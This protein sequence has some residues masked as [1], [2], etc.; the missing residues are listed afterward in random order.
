MFATVMIIV[1]LFHLPKRGANVRNSTLLL[2]WFLQ[3]LSN[4]LVQREDLNKAQ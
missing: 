3:A 2:K 4:R 1:T